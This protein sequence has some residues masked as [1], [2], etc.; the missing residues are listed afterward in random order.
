MSMLRFFLSAAL[1]AVIFVA[2]SET[3]AAQ[4]IV[5]I[6]Y[7]KTIINTN[8]DGE[9]V[10]KL[11]DARISS[12]PM[13]LVCDSAWQYLDRNEIH[14]FGNIQ[15]ETGTE[16]IWA[17]TLLYYADRDFSE[18]MGRV[19]INQ[20]ETTLFGNQVDYNFLTKEAYFND[21]IRLE[22]S[23]GVL[24][25][26]SGVYFQQLDSAEFRGNVQLAD[27]G[28][29]AESDSLFTNRDTKI[30]RLFDN[31]FIADSTENAIM[32]GNY[33]EAD[34]TGRRYVRDKAYLRKISADTTDTTHIFANEILLVKEDT[35]TIIHA[36]KDV[37]IWSEKFSSLSDSLLYNSEDETFTLSADPKA[38]YRNIQLNGP[39]I[40]V[41]L[42]SNEV[43]KLTSFTGTFTVQEDSVTGRLN[44]IK[45]DT[46][47]ADFDDGNISKI[48]VFPESKILYHTKNSEGEPDGAIEST[49]PKTILYFENQE[50]SQV[51]MGKNQGLF[52]PEYTDLDARRLEGFIWNPEQRPQRPES[53]PEALLPPVPPDR[54]FPLPPRFIEFENINKSKP[55]GDASP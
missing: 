31:I 52:L 42:D 51:W 39:N 18:L 48:Q 32:S 16:H 17:D 37:R 23:E 1:T 34:S 30:V 7:S 49:S 40:I 26:L 41:D 50:L 6:E 44:Q 3:A 35:T 36:F 54:P 4:N 38:W 53:V 47:I 55:A 27:S 22:D 11:Y 20:Q 10:R 8:I 19:I 43:E 5:N 21:N 45:G 46:L 13:A 12:G 14:A 33:V 9:P 24:T 2:V 15:I 29:Y 25:A 28:K